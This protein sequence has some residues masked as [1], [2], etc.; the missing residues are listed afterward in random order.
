MIY[1]ILGVN[2]IIN[3]YQNYYISFGAYKKFKKMFSTCAY[4]G[5]TFVP[6]DTKTL[7]HIVPKVRGGQRD[8]VN[9]IVVKRSW[10]SLRSDM[11]LGEFIDKYPQVQKNILNTL[12]SLKGTIINGINWADEVKKTLFKETGKDI[13]KVV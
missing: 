10:N 3:S 12:D 9:L 7:E 2:L 8:L 11:P 1:N 5:E 6:G 13:F 4:S